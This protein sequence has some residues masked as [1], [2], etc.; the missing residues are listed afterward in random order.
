MPSARQRKRQRLAKRQRQA[1]AR[2]VNAA[3]A[4]DP[5]DSRAEELKMLLPRR[6]KIVVTR[7]RAARNKIHCGSP[8]ARHRWPI[9]P[10]R[11]TPA[12]V[13]T[14]KILEQKIQ[15][16]LETPPAKATLR[17]KR[18]LEQGTVRQSFSH[19]RSK[20]VVVEKVK[21]RILTPNELRMREEEEA[22]QREEESARRRAEEEA[23]QLAEEEARRAEEETRRRAEE[24]AQQRAE[25]EARR[26]A[27]EETSPRRQS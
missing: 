19:G 15:G 5:G 27:E 8:N 6:W 21:R 10:L 24:E 22:R 23:R 3:K 25:Q 9:V 18:P 4:R 1:N 16:T 14:P 7:M 12:T 26:R 20:A 17:L 11:R 2:A 13:R